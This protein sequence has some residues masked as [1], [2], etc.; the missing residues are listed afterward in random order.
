MDEGENTDDKHSPKLIYTTS[1]TEEDNKYPPSI[2]L[3]TYSPSTGRGAGSMVSADAFTHLYASITHTII[4]KTT[5]FFI[6]SPF[7]LSA[8]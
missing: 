8:F 3:I 4:K 7:C 1:P 6:F 5:T 2:L